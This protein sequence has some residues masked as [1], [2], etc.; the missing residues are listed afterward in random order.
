MLESVMEKLA[1]QHSVLCGHSTGVAPAASHEPVHQRGV[2]G[3]V[4]IGDLRRTRQQAAVV[5]GHLQPGQ[6]AADG[7]GDA[8]ECRCPGR[9]SRAD[10]GPASGRR[11][12]ARRPAPPWRAGRRPRRYGGWRS[13]AGCSR[14]RRP[15]PRCCRRRPRGSWPAGRRPAAGR[16]SGRRWSRSRSSPS[17]RAAPGP[18]WRPPPA[19]SGGNPW[20][21]HRASSLERMRSSLGASLGGPAEQGLALVALPPTRGPESG[22]LPFRSIM[23]ALPASSKQPPG[24]ELERASSGPARRCARARGRRRGRCR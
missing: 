17:A 16:S 7:R 10:A 20:P 23:G 5:A 6:R 8:R 19:S 24:A 1:P 9:G 18:A 15:R 2:L 14:R 21:R 4:E 13:S 11:S 12:L 3:V 22:S